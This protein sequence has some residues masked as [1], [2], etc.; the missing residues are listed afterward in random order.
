MPS[1]PL[2][3]EDIL[4]ILSSVNLIEQRLDEDLAM[5][6]ELERDLDLSTDSE[7][8]HFAEAVEEL[9]DLEQ[10]EAEEIDGWRTIRDV[11]TTICNAGARCAKGESS[12]SSSSGSSDE[13]GI[14]KKR[15][16]RKSKN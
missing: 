5:N 14:L 13:S 15:R 8:D 2:Y 3:P 9:F 12:Y 6:T 1:H 4:E 11:I 7:R 10:I 16:A